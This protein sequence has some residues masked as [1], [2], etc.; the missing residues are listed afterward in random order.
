[1]TSTE[2][3]NDKPPTKEATAKVAAEAKHKLKKPFSFPIHK[4]D[5]QAKSWT[6]TSYFEERQKKLESQAPKAA[7]NI[8]QGTSI[9]FTSV[10]SAS[11]RTLEGIVWKNGGSVQKV[12]LR[13][14][15]THVVADNLAASKVEH[16]L[17]GDP[18]RKSAGVVVKPSWVVDSV[19]AGAM[20]PTWE[21]RVVR[22]PPDVADIGRFF[23][24]GKKRKGTSG[25]RIQKKTT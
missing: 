18:A 7:T 19:R 12:W 1:M 23:R 2:R 17:S 3:N 16:E 21:Y 9:Y 11:Q 22:G 20:L 13:K 4:K 8:L 25:A 6:R 10:K 5:R 24:P 14:R 15:V